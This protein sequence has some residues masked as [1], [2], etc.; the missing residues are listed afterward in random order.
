MRKIIQILVL[1]ITVFSIQ[2]SAQAQ[3]LPKVLL[4]GNYTYANPLGDLKDGYNNGMGFEVGGGFG[5]GKTILMASTG[6]INYSPTN[7]NS[8]LKV[9]PIKFGIRQNIILGLFANGNIG[10]A[11]QNFDNGPS[12]SGFL[13]E[14]G[15]GYK[16]GLFEVGL[17]YTGWKTPSPIDKNVNALLFKVGLAF[18]L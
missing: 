1:F 17:A 9:V 2:K 18:K 14:V 16:L 6:Y 15:A 12:G 10:W 4:F 5:M 13:Y 11:S 3:K 8:S 7:G